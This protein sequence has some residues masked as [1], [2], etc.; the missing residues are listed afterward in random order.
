LIDRSVR[1]V[2]KLLSEHTNQAMRDAHLE[3]E[4]WM[5]RILVALN[6]LGYTEHFSD[7]EGN[8]SIAPTQKLLAEAGPLAAEH[9]GR[10]LPSGACDL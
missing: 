2:A 4:A 8:L 9:H 10:G 6:D 1:A 7:H 5:R 3:P